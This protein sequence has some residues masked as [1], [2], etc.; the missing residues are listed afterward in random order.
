MAVSRPDTFFFGSHNSYVLPLVR[1]LLPLRSEIYPQNLS[2]QYL[3]VWG[4]NKG[5][6]QQR[7]GRIIQISLNEKLFLLS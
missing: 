7:R 2:T 5:E 6:V 1:G 3:V 4:S